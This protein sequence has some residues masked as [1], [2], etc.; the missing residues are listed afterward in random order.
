M[1]GILLVDKPSGWTSNDVVCKMKGVLHERRTGHSGT[2]DPMAT[3]LLPLFIGKATKA[4]EFAEKNRKKYIA[5]I[6]FGI[7]TDTQDIS[8]NIVS[9][10]KCTVT[11]HEFLEAAGAFSGD[12]EQIPPMYSALKQ[13]GKR[14]Y[15]LARQGIEIE[16]KPRKVNIGSIELISAS[17]VGFVFSVECSAGTYVRTLCHDIGQYLGCGACMYSL[18]RIKC[19]AF[20]I[21]DAYTLD[22]II[23]TAETGRTESLLL[24]MDSLFSD[25]TR[26]T[27]SETEESYIRNG[28]QLKTLLQDGRYT[29]YSAAG[30]F[31]ML[32]EAENGTLRSRKNFF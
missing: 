17:D 20:N 11:D 4:V 9:E 13:N 18:R 25:L 19:G 16:R 3:G 8:G 21:D 1:N 5:G 24:P 12:I 31:L 23:E 30:E 22:Q 28:R 29:V 32:A 2:L 7:V 27:C 15:D 10:H 26:Y 6:S 14:L